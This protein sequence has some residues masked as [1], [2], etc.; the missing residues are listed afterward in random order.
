MHTH[1]HRTRRTYLA[2]VRLSHPCSRSLAPISKLHITSCT[3]SHTHTHA[4]PLCE[5]FHLIGIQP[6]NI[7][8]TGFPLR[9][10][11]PKPTQPPTHKTTRTHTRHCTPSYT[12][13]HVHFE[14]NSGNVCTCFVG[15]CRR[16]MATM[17]AATAAAAT[18][19][20]AGNVKLPFVFAR[21]SSA[22]ASQVQPGAQ[23]TCERACCLRGAR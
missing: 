17:A 4:T 10:A 16:A 3:R 20:A 18:A 1:T 15:F 13:T 8:I 7:T 2:H 12:A 22:P 14:R 9:S 5:Y 6:A 11:Q 23:R 21:W 19:A